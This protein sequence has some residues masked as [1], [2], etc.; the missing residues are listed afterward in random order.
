M[1]AAVFTASATV[2]WHIGSGETPDA[3]HY[4]SLYDASIALKNH[5]WTDDMVW[6]ITSNLT[7]TLNC[8]IFN[9]SE[10]SFTIR[11]DA[12]ADRT[13][14][15]TS[16]KDNY[17]PSGNF[18]IGGISE[19]TDADDESNNNDFFDND[20]NIRWTSGTTRNLLIDGYAEGGSTRR[21]KIVGGKVGGTAILIYG[22]VASTTIKNC[23]VE[24]DRTGTSSGYD[25]TIRTEQ[26]SD[27]HPVGV[28]VDNCRLIST[29]STQGQGIY[30]NSS[31][32]SSTAG[33]VE[34]TVIRNCEIEVQQRGMFIWGARN[35]D[36]LNCTFRINSSATG[37]LAHGIY[38]YSY[39]GT[40]LAGTMNVRNCKF[41]ELKTNT[42]S[43]ND[44][45]IQ[46][47][48][49]SGGATV[50]NIENNIFTG[51]DA[52]NSGV[53]V[54]NSKLCGV[55]C[56]DSCVVRHNTFV[57]PQL[58]YA[59]STALTS[60]YPIALLYLAG[61]K[62]YIVE[63]NI[64][65]SHETAANNSLIRTS[66]PMDNVKHNVF[67]YDAGNAYITASAASCKDMDAYN[68]TY[69]AAASN[70]KEVQF[71]ADM[72]LADASIGDYDL[73]VAKINDVA[74]DINGKE[75][76]D[77][78]YAGAEAPGFLADVE[79][80]YVIGSNQAGGWAPNIGTELVK[81]SEN[82]FKY[83]VN[84]TGETYFAF[85]TDLANATGDEA[86][87]YVNARRFG[88][89]VNNKVLAK[90]DNV[91]LVKGTNAFKI[92]AAG[93]YTIT[94]DL[95]VMKAEVS[96]ALA[97]VSIAGTFPGATAWST[98]LYV[99]T[100]ANDHLSASKTIHLDA[101]SYQFKVVRNDAE[102]LSTGTTD[103]IDRRYNTKS[104]LETGHG[105][106][107]FIADIAGDYEFVF[108]YAD[109]SLDITFPD[110]VRAAA[111]TNYQSLCTP[112]DATVVG[113]T[114][115]ELVSA[116]GTAVNVRS[117][118]ELVAGH[119]YLLKPDAIGDIAINYVA[120]GA[121]TLTPVNPD[122]ST[123][124][125]FG[126]LVNT[127]TYQYDDPEQANWRNFFVLLDDD[128]FHQVRAGGEVTI[129][130]TRAYLRI[131]GDEIVDP[132]PA[133]IRII[134]NA[135]N[136]QDIEGQE[137][138]VKFIQNGQIY[139]QKNGVVYDAM[140]RVIR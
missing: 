17:G 58:T 130:P 73:A 131:A 48:T 99:L 12:D 95:N 92:T 8:G 25:I 30:F 79:H 37:L 45:G 122:A 104:N 4:T 98:N 80:L 42:T 62:H 20:D 111:N 16:S 2:T 108:T 32:K 67:Y 76:L 29:G 118:D 90:G 120:D 88:A 77:P 69:P 51:I 3:T 127:W 96:S 103:Q 60:A 113:A 54:K 129:T 5:T 107:N 121:I 55:R 14:A 47:I 59:P 137:K 52:I 78:T 9:P 70:W 56:G 22:D 128:K 1:L 110:F 86:W 63:N 7:E 89:D 18:V 105:N 109:N 24:C 26:N 39:N 114:A 133:P 35:L 43:N 125:F 15:F 97:K 50:W 116:D 123:T 139:I 119:S 136:I 65:V 134:E 61:S 53:T 68:T 91:D 21:L 6:L 138:A 28:V 84:I 75:R 64:F 117:V 10:Y 38:G 34:N 115:Y 126:E 112:F 66:A 100:E 135:T 85:V 31:K 33:L 41:I 101:G 27:I 72:S 74:T 102:W 82:V 19:N 36:V 49:A 83:D 140:G 94:I 13:I 93:F 87:A 11:P 106:Y 44:Y 40:G 23:I 124:G 81:V 71:N 57:M 132:T 46:G